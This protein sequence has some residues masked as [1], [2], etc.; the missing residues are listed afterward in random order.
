M[1]FYWIPVDWGWIV[2]IAAVITGA[3]GALLLTT[4]LAFVADLIGD[5]TVIRDCFFYSRI[6]CQLE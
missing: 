5:F 2:Y 4:S 6:F 3:G 1:L